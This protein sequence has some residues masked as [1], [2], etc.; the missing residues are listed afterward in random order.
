MFSPENPG[1]DHAEHPSDLFCF[2]FGEKDGADSERKHHAHQRHW[3]SGIVRLRTHLNKQACKPFSLDWTEPFLPSLPTGC[4]DSSM[5][6]QW[7]ESS[8]KQKQECSVASNFHF[9]AKCSHVDTYTW[10]KETKTSWKST[11]RVI[12]LEEFFRKQN[13]DTQLSKHKKSKRGSNS[14]SKQSLCPVQ[15]RIAFLS[16]LWSILSLRILCWSLS[17]VFFVEVFAFPEWSVCFGKNRSV[18]TLKS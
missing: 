14:E 12:V 7:N 9:S 18:K 6:C 2:W 13:Q 17:S 11:K 8:E 3:P 5:W 15:S 10:I 4:K 16:F 1:A